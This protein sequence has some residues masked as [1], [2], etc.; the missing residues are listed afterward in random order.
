MRKALVGYL[1]CGVLCSS[2]VLS[3]PTKEIDVPKQHGVAPAGELT[4]YAAA[5][6]SDVLQELSTEYAKQTGEK[7]VFNFSA[8]STLERQIEEG[9]PADVFFSADEEKMDSLERKGLLLAGTRHSLL[10]NSLVI[11]VPADASWQLTS[12]FDLTNAVIQRIAIAEPQSVPAGI[13]A[14]QY[15][16]KLGLWNR[17][18]SKCVPAE[19][20]RA[21]LA[22]IESGNVDAGI[23]Y[24]TDARISR[25]V[26]V[27]Y[28]VPP[29]EGPKISYPVAVLKD[30][31]AADA[32]K[33]L[34]HYLKSEAALQ[35]FRKY[36]FLVGAGPQ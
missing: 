33:R 30:S 29:A 16:S 21:A 24:K 26:R 15:L 28:E 36:G 5:S 17:L 34:I 10:S 4:V 22:A 19:N 11:V 25:T 13:Y 2:V 7:L 8:S 18:V 23:V 12:A 31:K 3:I 9:A 35:V 6:L 14:K 1:A 20:V 32:A 27:A